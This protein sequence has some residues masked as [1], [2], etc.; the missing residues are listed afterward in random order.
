MRLLQ[1]LKRL[2]QAVPDPGCPGC[3]DRRG[4]I[5]MVTCKQQRDGSI[6]PQEPM[7]TACAVCGKVREFV[8]DIRHLQARECGV[9]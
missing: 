7:P 3:P 9:A 1:R 4:R 5:A 6:V 2:E 8:V